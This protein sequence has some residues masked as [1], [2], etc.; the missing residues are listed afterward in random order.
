MHGEQLVTGHRSDYKYSSDNTY[1]DNQRLN[2]GDA[3]RAS[4]PSENSLPTIQ[5]AWSTQS[6]FASQRSSFSPHAIMANLKNVLF[7]RWFAAETLKPPSSSNRRARG[8]LPS[9]PSSS[10]SSA[11][12]FVS[13]CIFWY[14]TSALSS[15]TGKAILEQFRYPVTLTI[16]QFGFV[17]AYCLLFMSP[18]INIA[19]LRRPTSAILRATLP[20]GAFQVGGHMFSSMAISRIHVST[21]HTIKAL[22]P[23]FTVAAYALLFG[24]K[25]SPKTYLSLLPLTIGVMLAFTFDVSAS[26][27]T[28]L[29][30]AF[31]SA[32]VF[33]SSNI[34]F[35]KVMPS[36]SQTSSHKL[37]KLNLL[38]YSS[39]AAFVLMIPIWGFTDLPRLLTVLD[40]PAHA[41][42]DHG[43]PA[44]HSL[45]YY[46]IING[47][48]HFAQNIIAFVI[49]SS[50]SP[51]T[52]SIAS[53]IKRVWVIC[54]AIVWF[55]QSV[56]PIQGLGI[57]LTFVGLYMYN[58]AKGDVAKGESR[59]RR[60]EA[61][62][63]MM[64]P[65]NTAE[66]RL[67]NGGGAPS[68]PKL[69]DMDISSAMGPQSPHPPSLRTTRSP[70]PSVYGNSQ[71]N[72]HVNI[73]PPNPSSVF[74]K[75]TA[76]VSPIEPYPLPLPSLNSPPSCNILLG[77]PHPHTLGAQSM[78]AARVFA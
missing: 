68:S 43:L 33:V 73:S 66:E 71:R 31:G 19:K 40:N 7:R 5:G 44:I 11:I 42:P 54:M 69:L 76:G 4:S 48:V 24:V 34:F 50:T 65:S 10:T 57:G 64:L 20:M 22:S 32:L 3:W 30:C 37:D 72:L 13:L 59:M 77:Y 46:F 21:V 70:I 8:P 39:G 47:T 23:L 62:R 74:T 60:I 1:A 67:L 16:I 78:R 52:Y 61:T 29:L 51:V 27:P 18:V 56:H 49:L 25:Y 17:A 45:P 2:A 58:T 38:L 35:K 26:S 6:P 53:L 36:G 55:N 12:R 9:V 14:T 41:H 15:N 63:D 28:G 75:R